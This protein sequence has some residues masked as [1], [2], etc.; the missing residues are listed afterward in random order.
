MLGRYGTYLL[1]LFLRKKVCI[2]KFSYVYN[3]N[4]LKGPSIHP[5]Y[6]FNLLRSPV[7]LVLTIMVCVYVLK[8]IK[9]MTGMLLTSWA[10]LIQKRGLLLQTYRLQILF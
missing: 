6:S 9:Q 4:I 3:V 7:S 1:Y 8:Q 5:F 2:V 10:T